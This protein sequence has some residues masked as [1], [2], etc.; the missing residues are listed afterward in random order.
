MAGHHP[1]ASKR[2]LLCGTLVRMK[3]TSTHAA[4]AI[5]AALAAAMM[6][7]AALAQTPPADQPK[8][9]P[10]ATSDDKSA[11]PPE[12]KKPEAKKPAKE[13]AKSKEK[14]KEKAKE[15]TDEDA[16]KKAVET[17]PPETAPASDVPPELQKYAKIAAGG[18]FK[19]YVALA[20]E[21]QKLFQ[22]S[23]TL[24]M[25]MRGTE[26]TDAQREELA[27]IQGAIGKVS[28][29]MDGFVTGKT[30]TQDEYAA[31]DWIVQEQMRLHPL[32]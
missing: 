15:K 6:S 9:P 27:S 28:E 8:T 20:A 19:E 2:E 1:N 13:T 18:K 30:F 21:R 24:R 32:E 7:S 17:P 11:K 10:P 25:T 4:F 16:A 22:R 12:A 14:A 26:T 5:V 29:R 31:M 3:N 23:S